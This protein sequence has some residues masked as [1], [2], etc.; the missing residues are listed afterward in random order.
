MDSSKTNPSPS[1]I[2]TLWAHQQRAVQLAMSRSLEYDQ[3]AACPGL[4]I[5]FDLG[6]GK[7]GTV[8]SIVRG[9][10]NQKRE[11]LSTLIFAP[12]TILKQ[13]KR[14]FGNFTRIPEDLVY[15]LEGSGAKRLKQF[16]RFMTETKG[17]G[18]VVLSYSST[19]MPQLMEALRSWKPEVLVLDECHLVKN[20]TA[21]VTKEITKIA[22]K[23]IFKYLMTGTPVLKN[24]MDLYS[25]FRI[26]DGGATFGDSFFIFRKRYFVDKNAHM[27]RANYFPKWDVRPESMNFF[28]SA[29]ARVACMARKEECLSLPPLIEE[30]VLCGMGAEQ[31]KVYESMKQEFVAFVA[32]KR[33]GD[34]PIALVASFAIVKSIRLQQILAGFVLREDGSA[35]WFDDV[36]RLESLKELLEQVAGAGEQ[37]IVWCDFTHCYSVLLDI[38]E[39]VGLPPALLSG[40]VTAEQKSEAIEGFKSGKYRAL[41]ANPQ[42]GG[43]GLDLY[44]ARVAIYYTRPYNSGAFWQSQGRNYRGGSEMHEKVLHYHL[45]CEGTMDEVIMQCLLSK[46]DIAKAILNFA[47]V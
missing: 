6:T 4:F 38:L 37:V 5:L 12:M 30:R 47:S 45:Y 40:T 28:N 27:P 14:E 8:C 46:G 23:S 21:M 15:V 25:Q 7:T 31:A 1:E 29:L 10:W 20:P 9:L 11:R 16:E 18:I 24:A 17:R 26:L 44:N 19:R 32:D 41:V 3:T 36:P 42:S 13:W 34:E 22:D 33:G 39:K 2:R 43:A 35:Q